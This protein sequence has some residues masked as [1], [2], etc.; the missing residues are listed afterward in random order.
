[1][2]KLTMEQLQEIAKKMTFNKRPYVLFVNPRDDDKIE[3]A[4]REFPDAMEAYFIVKTE[5][6]QE[7]KV[8]IVERAELEEWIN[9][10]SPEK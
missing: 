9:G 8:A 4:K 2:N 3:E 5:S 6:I 10:K 7:G 1:M